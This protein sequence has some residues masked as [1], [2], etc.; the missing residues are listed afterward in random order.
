MRNEMTIGFLLLFQLLI[1][2][3]SNLANINIWHLLGDA[4]LHILGGQISASMFAQHKIGPCVSWNERRSCLA[5][6]DSS[7]PILSS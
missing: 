5:L 3:E 2:I 6:A 4:S 7:V 1:L